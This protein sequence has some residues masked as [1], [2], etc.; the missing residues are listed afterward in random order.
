MSENHYFMTV[1]RDTAE[2][3]LPLTWAEFSKRYSLR[4]WGGLG[5][6]L[7]YTL[8]CPLLPANPTK[9]QVAPFRNWTI[10]TTLLRTFPS[11][12]TFLNLTH[13]S[14]PPPLA[15]IITR[16]TPETLPD[17]DA[18]NAT[19]IAAYLRGSLDART[20]WAVL[21]LNDPSPA[22]SWAAPSPHDPLPNAYIRQIRALKRR[23]GRATPIFDWQPPGVVRDGHLALREEDTARFAAFVKTAWRS[24]WPVWRRKAA[25]LRFR[26][27]PLA[28]ELHAKLSALRNCCLVHYYGIQPDNDLMGTSQKTTKLTI[29]LEGRKTGSWR[30]H[31]APVK[32]IEYLY[33]VKDGNYISL[34]N[35]RFAVRVPNNAYGDIIVQPLLTP[36]KKVW[37]GLEHLAVVLPRA[38]KQGFKS[39]VYAKL[40]LA[41][42][43]GGGTK[44]GV[45]RGERNLLPR[46][47]QP[48]L[49][50]MRL[51]LT[52]TTTRGTDPH[53]QV[54]LI[55]RADHRTM[56]KLYFALKVWVMA[57]RFLFT[58]A[59]RKGVT[60]KSNQ[61]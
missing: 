1:H 4:W 40:F 22:R 8:H 48:F 41:K 16:N 18:L 60:E 17:C 55:P 47:F 45:S 33:S 56:L 37:A 20:C 6:F 10:R 57:D 32:G 19:A 31:H 13:S 27:I 46:W 26:D 49:W 21:T 61:G 25:A 11:Y 24:N 39:L 7:D 54:V 59:A 42:P 2:K 30:F 38:T 58:R 9:Q 50:R 34:N 28:Q 29:R 51:K 53:A 36:G 3:L 15:E 23:F 35:W 52:V 14:S 5:R 12:S 44:V 43:T